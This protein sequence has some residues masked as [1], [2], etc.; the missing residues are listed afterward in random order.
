MEMKNQTNGKRELRT[1]FS[2]LK[3]NPYHSFNVSFALMSVIPLLV[4]FYLVATKFFTVEALVG[5][6]GLILTLTVFISLIGYYVGY[7]AIR[8]VLNKVLFY[9]A[10]ARSA[11]SKLRETQQELIQSAKRAVVGELAGGVAHEVKNP[12][13]TISM[14]ADYLETR[15]DLSAEERHEKI[16]KM[17]EAIAHAD[18]IVKSLLNFSGSDPLEL[19]PCGLNDLIKQSLDL[20]G[21]KISLERIR[22]REDLAEG[23]PMV[24]AD[25]NQ[26]KQVFINT[27]LN[28]LQ[29]MPDGGDLVLRTFVEKLDD[30]KEGVGTRATDVFR[31]GED[32]IV[33][34]VRDT[35][36][37][38]PPGQSQKV[39]DP[40]F[41]SKPVGQG[42]GLGL[43]VIKSIVERHKGLIGIESAEGRGT[44][45]I[46]TLPVA[47]DVV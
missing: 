44:K 7:L 17:K 8:K 1:L 9:A 33:C 26:L 40:F 12:L 5:N 30:I 34:E 16:G 23:L 36:R 29:A 32:G 42:P 10:S 46:I 39:F 24:M 45:V 6:T 25:E 31:P 43:T 19:R 35:G 13:A 22:V 47:R 3:E 27:I 11:Y 2:E 21:R 20:V 41:T 15:P 14:C 18:R 38:I 37:G 28:S 4:F